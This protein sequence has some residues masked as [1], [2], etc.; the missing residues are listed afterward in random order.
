MQDGK[1]GAT[2][3]CISDASNMMVLILLTLN[4]TLIPKLFNS[5]KMQHE[6]IHINQVFVFLIYSNRRDRSWAYELTNP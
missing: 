6:V 1:A 4:D 2:L 5:M 3:I